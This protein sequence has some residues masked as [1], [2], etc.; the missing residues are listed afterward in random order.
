MQYFFTSLRSIYWI[1]FSSTICI[2]ILLQPLN[3]YI[4]LTSCS[5]KKILIISR[6]HGCKNLYYY[7]ELTDVS[8]SSCTYWFS[9]GL[10]KR[11]RDIYHWS[12]FALIELIRWIVTGL[13]IKALKWLFYK[14][15]QK[16]QVDTTIDHLTNRPQ[17]VRLKGCVSER[18]VSSTGAPQLTVSSFLFS[19]YTSDF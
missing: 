3:G 10:K 2:K 9:V 15:L 12:S 18:V 4:I 13:N 17:F 1:C 5:G 6:G 19:Q 8:M 11:S 16:I 7:T 14:K